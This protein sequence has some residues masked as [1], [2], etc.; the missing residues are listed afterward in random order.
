MRVGIT[1][2]DGTPIADDATLVLA[3][4]DF[5]A[6]G[7]EAAFAELRARGAVS[8]EHGVLVR[9]E[10]ARMLEARGGRITAGGLYDP[11]DPRVRFEGTRPLSCT[12]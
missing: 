6:T 7:T 8:I 11:A 4:T 12:P 2:E 1:R 5:L 10:M 3:T 9:E